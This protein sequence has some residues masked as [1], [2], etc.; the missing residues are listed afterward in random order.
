MLLSKLSSV[1]KT[2]EFKGFTFY[3]AVQ[4][5]KLFLA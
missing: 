2:D 1:K 3:P 4:R 5:I